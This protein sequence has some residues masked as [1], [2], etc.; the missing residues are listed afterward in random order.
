[1]DT[2]TSIS[3]VADVIG[4]VGAVFALFAWQQA[5]QIR[6]ELE[7]EKQRQNRTIKIVLSYG[8]EKI[9]L[10][11]PL[12]RTELTRQEVLGRIGMIPR[13]T[14]APYSIRYL[15][16]MDFWEQLTQVMEGPGDGII[17]ISLK[18]EELEQFDLPR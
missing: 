3:L 1:M 10:P 16:T 2:L 18:E 13:K 8:D 11:V 5:R 9:E 14:K 4:I 12:L 15:N 17:S 6:Q 7:S